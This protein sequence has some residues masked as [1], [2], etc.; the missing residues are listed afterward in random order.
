MGIE[1]VVRDQFCCAKNI[2]LAQ[3]SYLSEF[4]L[5]PNP[6]LQDVWVVGWYLLIEMH[7][8]TCHYSIGLYVVIVFYLFINS[9]LYISLSVN[10]INF[11]HH[12][13]LL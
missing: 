5:R 2:Y 6:K 11:S 1:I 7:M 8:H 12:I 10:N 9:I 4:G 3:N 13:W